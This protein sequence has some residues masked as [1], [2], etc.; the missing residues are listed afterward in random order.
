MALLVFLNPGQFIYQFGFQPSPIAF[1][2][3]A[4]AMLYMFA[5]LDQNKGKLFYW[6]ALFFTL[7]TLIRTTHILFLG[8]MGVMLILKLV[9]GNRNVLRTLDGKCV[10]RIVCG[11]LLH[12]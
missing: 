12:L 9:Q 6:A 2:F 3:S 5:A 8:A 1:A 10:G 11:G 4:L 7:A